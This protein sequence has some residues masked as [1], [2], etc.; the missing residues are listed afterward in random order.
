MLYYFTYLEFNYRIQN[1]LY[2]TNW[3]ENLKKKY[4]SVLKIR[5]SMPNEE[6]ILLL[7]DKVTMDSNINY[8]NYEIHNFKFDKQLFDEN[9]GLFYY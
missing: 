2:T 8:M 5:N 7:Q 3:V 9:I 4:R 1:M 6:S